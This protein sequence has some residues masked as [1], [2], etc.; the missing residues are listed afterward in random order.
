MKKF[1][2][3]E[4]EFKDVP[5]FVE[6]RNE[7]RTFLSDDSEYTVEESKDWFKNKLNGVQST[8]CSSPKFFIIEFDGNRIGYFR[9]SDWSDI[10]NSV[11][12]GADL[13][14][15]SRGKGFSKPMFRQF[16]GELN[17]KGYDLYVLEVLE[18]NTRARNLYKQLGFKE[19]DVENNFV[20]RS[21]GKQINKIRMVMRYEDLL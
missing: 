7:C 10:T 5:F 19:Q 21:S 6:V 14:K 15:N 9:T 17:D 16:L 3:R 11:W 1:K 2:I 20:T 8:G 13:H 18:D 12:V 4:M